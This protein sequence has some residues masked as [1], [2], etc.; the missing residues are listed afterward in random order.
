MLAAHSFEW[1][2]ASDYGLHIFAF[3]ERFRIPYRSEA[4]ETLDFP[5]LAAD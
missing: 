2:N 4:A 3:S 1:V 5:L